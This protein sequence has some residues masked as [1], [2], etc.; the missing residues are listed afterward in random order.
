MGKQVSV[1][2]RQPPPPDVPAELGGAVAAA[3]GQP[4]VGRQLGTPAA[5]A[6][7]QGRWRQGLHAAAGAELRT[8][9]RVPIEAN[10]G[11]VLPPLTSG[12]TPSPRILCTQLKAQR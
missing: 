4:R 10:Y 3:S 7:A 11:S 9:S 2:T 6:C 5:T 1:C 12:D 8:R